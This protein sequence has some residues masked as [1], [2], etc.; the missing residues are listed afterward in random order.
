LSYRSGAGHWGG[1]SRGYRRAENGE[2]QE[3]V[4]EQ[5]LAR[6]EGIIGEVADGDV[7]EAERRHRQEERGADDLLRVAQQDSHDAAPLP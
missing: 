1:V 5:F 4:D 2:Q 6:R 7:D 3:A